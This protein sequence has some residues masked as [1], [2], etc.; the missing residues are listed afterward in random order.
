[1]KTRIEICKICGLCYGAQRALDLTIE[2]AK[3]RKNVVL[4]KQLLHNKYTVDKLLSLGVSQKDKLEDITNKDFVILRAHGE[5]KS[6]YNYLESH[7][8]DFLDC[9]CPNVLNI[10]KHVYIKNAEGYKIIII[11]K[12][13]KE[14]GQ[15]HPE[16]KAV[17]SY[18]DAPILIEDVN[19][20]NKITSDNKKY[21]LVIQTTF[22][23]EKS[24]I[25]I[26]EIKL[27]LT[28]LKK[29]FDMVDTTCQAQLMIKKQSLELAKKVD[30]ML[31][32]GGSNSSNTSELYYL[33]KKVCPTFFI[34]S[35]ADLYNLIQENKVVSGQFI[36]LTAGASTTRE[37]IMI[38]KEILSTL[39]TM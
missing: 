12:Y 19:D 29:T 3:N 4:F 15:M 1:M 35:K 31:V 20:I 26:N 11:G 33:L 2:Q 18:C 9:T 6:T 28:K 34:E 37:E 25:I 14:S 7:Q 32:I 38:M 24:K 10:I 21:F 27:K 13:G 22:P 5:E 8:I 16:V 17:A 39:Y 36:G 23:Q 30:I